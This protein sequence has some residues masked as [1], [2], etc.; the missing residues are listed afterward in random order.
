MTEEVIFLCLPPQSCRER[1]REGG[2]S[3]PAAVWTDLSEITHDWSVQ[4]N[5]TF[6]LVECEQFLFHLV[7]CPEMLVIVFYFCRDATCIKVCI[8]LTFEHIIFGGVQ[9]NIIVVLCAVFL[10]C[11]TMFYSSLAQSLPRV[12]LHHPKTQCSEV[13]WG[14][15]LWC[16]I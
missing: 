6:N 14:N 5:F 11:L 7:L 3:P 8:T 12:Y 13:L 1:E 9:L 4:I 2:W 10:L 15:L 16:Q